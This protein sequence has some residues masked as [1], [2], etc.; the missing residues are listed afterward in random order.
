M[1]GNSYTVRYKNGPADGHKVKMVLLQDDPPDIS[2]LELYT[3][4]DAMTPIG[5]EDITDRSRVGI[6]LLE[7]DLSKLEDDADLIYEF[8]EMMDYG[9]F[10]KEYET[11][12]DER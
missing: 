6:Y 9:D 8:V 12:D 1:V 5:Q 10:L 11:E 4:L 3:L 7:N 2:C